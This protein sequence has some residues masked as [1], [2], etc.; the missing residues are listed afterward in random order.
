[1]ESAR[2]A[3]AV[4]R[5]LKAPGPIPRE[6]LSQA[7]FHASQDFGGSDSVWKTARLAV[8]NASAGEAFC[9]SPRLPAPHGCLPKTLTA[10][11]SK[12]LPPPAQEENRIR[13]FRA[14]LLLSGLKRQDGARRTSSPNSRS[15]K[16][17]RSSA[18]SRRQ[19]NA[20][21]CQPSTTT[22]MRLCTAS[23]TA[24]PS[25]ASRCP[26]RSAAPGIAP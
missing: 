16:K 1:M 19:S 11:R 20:S 13:P 18:A 24:G 2:R 10:R 5:R 7:L 8:G 4:T 14:A 23:T 3:R 6:Q 9:L 15:L 22:P 26:W 17:F 25:H 21:D 12:E